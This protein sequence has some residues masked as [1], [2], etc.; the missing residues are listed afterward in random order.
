MRRLPAWHDYLEP[1]S[2][3][4]TERAQDA[5]VACLQDHGIDVS[6]VGDIDAA[7]ANDPD[8]YSHCLVEV[9]LS[10]SGN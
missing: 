7:A 6:S 3:Q 8:T 2:E 1:A 4:E 9:E 5:V 10:G